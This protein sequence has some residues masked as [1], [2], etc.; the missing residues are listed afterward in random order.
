MKALSALG[1]FA[2][3]SAAALPLSATP[4]FCESVSGNL[5]ANCGFE[6]GDFTDWTQGGPTGN[7][8][9]NGSNV[10]T[11][12]FAAFLGAVGS[13]STLSQTLLSLAGTVDI[14]FYLSGDGGTP[15]DFT[16]SWDGTDIGPDLVNSGGFGYTQYDLGT[17]ASV[18]NDTLTFQARDDPGFWG[19]DDVVVTQTSATPEPGT[20]GMVLAGLGMVLTG[21]RARRRR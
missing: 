2:L 8:G 6:T 3:L 10:N 15:N 19:L 21:M 20:I 17:F 18:G 5:V 12:S 1:V 4:S 13:D 14:S 9:V 16:V 7:D 11:G